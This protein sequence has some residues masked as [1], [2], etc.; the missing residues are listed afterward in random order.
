MALLGCP[1]DINEYADTAVTERTVSWDSPP[2]FVSNRLWWRE[3]DEGGGHGAVWRDHS[4]T[5][6][7]THS[8]TRVCSCFSQLLPSSP[9]SVSATQPQFADHYTLQLLRDGSAINAALTEATVP[10]G[11]TEFVYRS[12]EVL[13]IGQPVECSFTVC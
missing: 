7:R 13:S 3:R 4:F 2:T 9:V 11:Q 10:V 1:S 12:Q 8:S 6:S 5:S